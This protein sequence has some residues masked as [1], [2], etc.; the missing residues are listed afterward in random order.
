MLQRA[1]TNMLGTNENIVL[2]KAS[3]DVKNQI[4]ILKVKK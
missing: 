2:S 1:I 4:E 3:K